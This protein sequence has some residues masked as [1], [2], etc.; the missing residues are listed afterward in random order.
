MEFLVE[1]RIQICGRINVINTDE[2]AAEQ[3]SWKILKTIKHK[4]N[5]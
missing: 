5:K 2:G 3:V 1:R 4:N